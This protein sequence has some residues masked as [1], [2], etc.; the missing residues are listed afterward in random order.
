[1]RKKF[2][3]TDF[4]CIEILIGFHFPGNLRILNIKLDTRNCKI[5]LLFATFFILLRSNETKNERN[6]KG[7]STISLK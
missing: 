5:F 2:H 4:I 7:K 3:Y 6:N 1:M